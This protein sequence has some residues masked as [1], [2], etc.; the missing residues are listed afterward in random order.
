MKGGSGH[1][2]LSG[3]FAPASTHRKRWPLPFVTGATILETPPGPREFLGMPRLVING[4]ECDAP[5][6]ATIQDLTKK[7]AEPPGDVKTP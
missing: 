1:P 7:G 5:A 6:G 4:H 3:M 2:F